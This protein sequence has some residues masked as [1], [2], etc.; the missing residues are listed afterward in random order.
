M[1]IISS[2]KAMND[3]QKLKSGAVVQLSI[4]QITGLITNM[5]DARKNLTTEQYYRV[6]DLFT[7]LKKCNTKIEM[8]LD[9][10][11]RTCVDIIKKFDKIAPYEKYSGGNE[12]EFSFLM[13]DIRKDDSEEEILYNIWHND[14]KS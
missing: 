9:E 10:Y 8:D 4:G 3:I 11:Y 6:Y 12:L 2:I 7:K 14:K 1:G 13:D 5:L